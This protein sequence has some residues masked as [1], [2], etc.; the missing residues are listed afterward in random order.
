[1]SA[2]KNLTTIAIVGGGPAALF[3]YK[4]LV[5]SAIQNVEVHIFE[6]KDRLGAGM[7][8]SVEGACDEHITNV[9]ANEIPLIHTPMTDW[10]AEAPKSLQEHYGINPGNFNDYKVFPRLFFGAYLTQQFEALI[11]FGKHVGLKT[12]VHLNTPVQDISDDEISGKVKLHLPDAKQLIADRLIIC[13]GHQWP[14][15]FEEKV[16]GWFDSPYPPQKLAKS[17]NFPVAIKGS[18]LTAIDAVR[19]LARSNG[20]FEKTADHRLNYVLNKESEGFKMVLHS[21]DGLMPAVRFHLEDT[22]L[23]QGEMIGEEEGWKI[24]EANNGFIPL[25]LIY[26]RNFLQP[27]RA[28]NPVFYETVKDMTIEEFVE[29]MMRRREKLDGFT[30]FEAEYKEA[31]KSIKRQ[32]SVAWK[33]MLA[34]L[35]YAVNYPAKHLSAEDMLR[36]KKVL[37]PLISIVIAFVPQTS[38]R[39]MLALHKAGVLDLVPVDKESRV[40]PGE[41][42]ATYYHTDENG[43][44]I[45]TAYNMY[46]DATGQ[47]VFT[48]ED[49][50]FKSLVEGG[51]VS[52]AYINF[53]DDAAGALEMELGNKLVKKNAAGHFILK[54]PGIQIN[55]QF[56]VLN[57]AGAYNERI[58]IMAVPHIGGLNPDYSGLDFC[59]TAS[60]RIIK[61]IKPGVDALALAA[62]DDIEPKV[63]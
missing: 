31:E 56:Q 28:Q 8:Y 54:V 18:A 38:C 12:T 37:M 15:K 35:S 29:E 14:K 22:H 24:K 30:L 44:A 36:L 16:P 6:K 33:E 61:S 48:L 23:S 4:R 13:T 51:T 34:T 3:M 5:E 40:D 26:Q 50:P 25:D 63:A 60:A 49:F 10:I 19:T 47:P 43:T 53:K 52:A 7:P 42:G 27:L 9:S 46:V 57:A 17:V 2:T 41:K 59:E 1:M 21:L 62:A 58:Y 11:K 55:D 32:E 45:Q 39:E 20:H